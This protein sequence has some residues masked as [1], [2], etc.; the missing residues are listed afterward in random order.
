M[1]QRKQTLW[2]LLAAL[3]S[4][5][6]FYFDLYRYT[7]GVIK[8]NDH[9]PSLLIALVMTILP[10]IDVF[11]FRNRKRQVGIAFGGIIADIGFISVVLMREGNLSKLTPPP[12]G[13]TY[14]I[15]AVLPVISII[16]LILAIS[17]MRKDEKLVRSADRLR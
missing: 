5:G 8:V 1:I 17:G 11:M 7:G 2:L 9:Y 14:W 4:A 16:F 10:L 6:V 3:F 15:G 13:G 12:V